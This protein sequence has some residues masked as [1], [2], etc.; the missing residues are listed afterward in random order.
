MKIWKLR[1]NP[2]IAPKTWNSGNH[3]KSGNSAKKESRNY[4]KV[5]NYPNS[6]TTLDFRENLNINE[7]C[8][9]NPKIMRKSKKL[10]QIYKSNN[11]LKCIQKKQKSLENF[12]IFF[13]Y[14]VLYPK[15]FFK[16]Q[17]LYENCKIIENPEIP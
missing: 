7:N 11:F 10:S 8:T 12:Q 4:I 1:K 6:K 2:K 15:N 5:E 16:S 17:D 9:K 14:R 13:N 3:A